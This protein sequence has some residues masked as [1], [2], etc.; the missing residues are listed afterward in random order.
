MP[1]GLIGSVVANGCD[2]LSCTGEFPLAPQGIGGVAI[3][4]MGMLIHQAAHSFARWFDCSIASAM[5]V[6]AM[7]CFFVAWLVGKENGILLNFTKPKTFSK[8][9]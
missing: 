7:L 9:K 2:D 3:D 6:V 4:G 1:P 8:I 5:V